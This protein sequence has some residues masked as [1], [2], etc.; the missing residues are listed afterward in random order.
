MYQPNKITSKGHLKGLIKDGQDFPADSVQDSS[1]MDFYPEGDKRRTPYKELVDLSTGT[2]ALPSGYTIDKFIEKQFVDKDGNTKNCLI[3]VCTK[4]ANPTRIFIKGYYAPDTTS[5]SWQNAYKTSSFGWNN[6][7][8]E[9]TERYVGGSGYT[10]EAESHYISAAVDN[11]A[12]LIKIT[13][14]DAHNLSTNDYVWI[15]GVA[16]TTE[17]N[18]GWQVTVV[19][20]DEFTLNSSTY[21]NTYTGGGVMDK[22][23]NISGTY[24]NLRSSD[25]ADTAAKQADNYFKGFFVSTSYAELCGIVLHSKY[26]S[27]KLHAFVEKSD[28]D[29]LDTGAGLCRFPVN[30][31]NRDN[32]ANISDV[33]FND[34]NPGVLQILCGRNSRSLWLGFINER[35]YFGSYTIPATSDQAWC[36]PE[37][38]YTGEQEIIYYV[39]V[40]K[41]LSSL[42]FY[43]LVF[44]WK[45]NFDHTTYQTFLD[46]TIVTSIGVRYTLDRGVVVYINGATHA[47]FTDNTVAE[48]T[49]A[50][51]DQEKGWDGFWFGFDVPKVDNKSIYFRHVTAAAGT[52]YC[53][54]EDIGEELG[55]RFSFE[56]VAITPSA[57][58]DILFYAI[59][60]EIDGYQNVFVKATFS[61]VT[62]T[63]EFP[64]RI[65]VYFEQWFDRRISASTV[66]FNKSASFDETNLKLNSLPEM[67]L[68]SDAYAGRRTVSKMGSTKENNADRVTLIDSVGSTSTDDLGNAATGLSLNATLGHYAWEDVWIKPKY[69]IRLGELMIGANFSQDSVNRDDEQTPSGLTRNGGEFVCVSAQ[70]VT[71]TISV[72]PTSRMQQVT[73]G[74]QIKGIAAGIGNRFLILT[75]KHSYLYEVTDVARGT[76]QRVQTFPYRGISNDKALV[77]GQV[78]GEYIGNYWLNRD[79]IWGFGNDYPQDKALNR[80]RDYWQKS[81]TDA[82]KTAAIGGFLPRTKEVFWLIGSTIYIWN[83]EFEHFKTYSFPDTPLSFSAS[84]DGEMYFNISNKIYTTVSRYTASS[85]PLYLD[86]GSTAIAFYETWVRTHGMRNIKKILDRIELDYVML[87]TIP[88]GEYLN[89]TLKI[90]A[91]S[92]T[93]LNDIFDGEF[94]AFGGSYTTKRAHTH[95]FRKRIPGRYYTVKVASKSADEANIIDFELYEVG[96]NVLLTGRP[97]TKD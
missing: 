45:N 15:Q 53:N 31:Y 39:K 29:V 54:E 74:E 70:Q 40:R 28:W 77:S 86:K 5:K 58:I 62:G 94:T 56:K 36:D 89:A 25:I 33:R 44:S 23:W 66:F 92:D 93:L 50:D 7:W 71:G 12:G 27:T 43:R 91:G 60:L 32:W 75:E 38:V 48:F 80:I 42:G 51:S 96:L 90:T 26:S 3:V 55:I 63:E 35:R 24:Y 18:G 78:A 4:A 37:G 88:L 79:S 46:T 41:Y 82:N 1:N 13:T 76:V 19:D 9:L 67:F 30:Q 49:V 69:M 97:L 95:N 72:F 10:V 87:T 34:E 59:G 6:E 81:I 73:S 2:Y 83:A 20:A 17:A 21:A 8:I 65:K 57:P 68:L 85:T 14:A 47:A 84:V 11:G 22:A 16:G 64:Q 52:E 61:G